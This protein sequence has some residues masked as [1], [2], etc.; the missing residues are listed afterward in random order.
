MNL[1]VIGDPYCD[2]LIMEFLDPPSF[3]NFCLTCKNNLLILQKTIQKDLQHTYGQDILIYPGMSIFQWAKFV[4]ENPS[5]YLIAYAATANGIK[6]LIIFCLEKNI[7][8]SERALDKLVYKGNLELL[9]FFAKFRMYPGRN[10]ML[11]AASDGHID[12]LNFYLELGFN[13]NSSV[14]DAAA[15]YGR[16]NVL[17]FLETKGVLASFWG[18]GY[19]IA[20]RHQEVIDYLLKFPSSYNHTHCANMAFHYKNKLLLE[21][22]NSL[23]VYHDFIE[24]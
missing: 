13:L 24:K 15:D 17:I 19:A 9:K 2:G 20:K 23:G 21:K 6:D 8:I 4:K 14:A 7:F 12:I 10:S 5:N 16:L 1:N 3:V 22:L 11:W 18:F